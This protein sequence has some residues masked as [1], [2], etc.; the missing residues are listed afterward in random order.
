[1]DL[2]SMDQSGYETSGTTMLVAKD[3]MDQ[4]RLQLS[5]RFQGESGSGG[6][7]DMK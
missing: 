5:G 3:G 4:W 6:G 2:P 1:M 7:K